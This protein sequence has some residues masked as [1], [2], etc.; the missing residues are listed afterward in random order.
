MV[1]AETGRERPLVIRNLNSDI[2]SVNFLLPTLSSVLP[3]TPPRPSLHRSS[4]SSF[5]YVSHSSSSPSVTVLFTTRL[6]P[7]FFPS[8]SPLPYPSAS[9]SPPLLPVVLPLRLLV[10]FLPP[11][12]CRVL[13]SATLS[14][15]SPP[16]S[17]SPPPPHPSLS[18]SPPN[19]SSPLFSIFLP[20]TP[21]RFPF[22]VL[23]PST[24]SVLPRA[25]FRVL[26]PHCSFPQAT[27]LFTC[28]CT[29]LSFPSPIFHRS[30]PP[31]QL[32]PTPR[33]LHDIINTSKP[34]CAPA[35]VHD[36]SNLSSV[37]SLLRVR[38]GAYPQ[39]SFA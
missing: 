23:L 2:C 6:L 25:L 17:P 12:P 11:S 34:C 5:R 4:R 10:L 36:F 16:T 28:T 9:F 24:I 3:A 38:T 33:C 29:R 7:R 30:P 27:P 22:T 18:S 19:C 13:L 21:L 8:S 20:S 35:H 14:G 32:L 31:A 39:D 15:R 37:L 1:I 26:L